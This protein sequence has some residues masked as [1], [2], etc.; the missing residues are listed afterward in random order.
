MYNNLFACK[1]AVIEFASSRSK[2]YT[3]RVAI[4]NDRLTGMKEGKVT[5]SYRDYR[6]DNRYRSMIL[7]VAEFARRFLQHILPCGFYKI[8]YLDIL[9]VLPFDYRVNI[10]LLLG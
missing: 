5:F 3:Y 1:T 9:A 2:H 4:S 7:E 10:R 6:K 8:R